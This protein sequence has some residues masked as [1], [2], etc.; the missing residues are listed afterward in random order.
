MSKALAVLF[1]TLILTNSMLV[2][3]VEIETDDTPQKAEK[4]TDTLKKEKEA[5]WEDKIEPYLLEIM[6]KAKDNEKIPVWLWLEEIDDSIIEDEVY[7]RTGLKEDN[8]A[9]VSDTISDKLA[10]EISGMAEADSEEQ[11]EI[12]EEFQ[13]YLKRTEKARKLEKER[14]E[15]YIHELRQVQKEMYEEYNAESLKTFDISEKDLIFIDT[16]APFYTVYLSKSDIQRIAKNSKITSIYYYDEDLTFETAGNTLSETITG[17]T[18]SKVKNQMNLT[19]N[20]VKVG[21]ID[22]SPLISYNGIS[23]SRVTKIDPCDKLE[24]QDPK[25]SARVARIAVGNN[26]IASNSHLYLSAANSIPDLKTAI[27]GQAEEDVYLINYSMSTSTSSESRTLPYYGI[28]RMF[29][30]YVAKKKIVVVNAA[31][32]NHGEIGTPGLAYNI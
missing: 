7:R 15:N 4:Q 19:G 16:Q 27:L 17:S 3:A 29:D 9:V 1:S 30:Y 28:E 25:H 5:S 14:V 23:Q 10:I 13:G 32:N 18:I 20:E 21:I 2:S 12:S 6:E 31:G 8:L 11:K 26:G 22:G 24:G